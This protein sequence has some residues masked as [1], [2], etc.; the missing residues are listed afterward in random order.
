MW[1]RYSN[2]SAVHMLI[3]VAQPRWFWFVQA[4]THGV[5]GDAV[6]TQA[7]GAQAGR[8][9]SRRLDSGCVVECS[10]FDAGGGL[11]LLATD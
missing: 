3:H 2:S 11:N 4:F 1:S 8:R 9:V 7:V 10:L 6:H 5:C